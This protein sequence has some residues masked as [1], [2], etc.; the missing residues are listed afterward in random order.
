MLI[1]PQRV[2]VHD[3]EGPISLLRD[4]DPSDLA[5]VVDEAV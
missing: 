4:L 1:P 3:G 2:D 5:R